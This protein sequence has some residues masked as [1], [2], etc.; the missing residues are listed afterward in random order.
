MN[1]ILEQNSAKMRP[2]YTSSENEQAYQ[3]KVYMPGVSRENI[4]IN[5]EKGELSISG[6]RSAVPAAWRT[7]SRESASADY[8]LRL[9]L[10]VEIDGDNIGAACENG[11]L[12][13]NLPKAESLKPRKIEIK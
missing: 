11:V 4:S 2:Y 8:Q 3:V 5:L 10:N 12:T 9:V 7:L 13:L 1:N 6:S